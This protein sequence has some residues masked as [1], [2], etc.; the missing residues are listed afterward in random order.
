MDVKDATIRQNSVTTAT[1]EQSFEGPDDA[2]A[3]PL[4][5]LDSRQRALAD[6]DH[7]IQTGCNLA[8]EQ[9]SPLKSSD[10]GSAV[11]VSSNQPTVPH[12]GRCH[13]PYPVDKAAKPCAKC[14]SVS[15]CSRECQKADF[16]N[17]K[18]MCA[19]AAQAYASRTDFRMET[20]GSH[21]KSVKDGFRAGLQKWQFDT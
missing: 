11:V 5:S 19:A 18:K 4:T 10:S 21:N 1:D 15:Y 9:S 16:R 3:S 17:H 7:V 6:K 12:C 8:Q 2:T 13:R 14:Q 20:R